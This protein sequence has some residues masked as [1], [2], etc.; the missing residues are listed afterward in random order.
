MVNNFTYS[1]RGLALTESFESCL[2]KAY[3]DVRGVWTIGYGHTGNEV[4]PGLTVTQAQAE[5]WLLEDIQVAVEAVNRL[6]T[7]PLD[8]G[9]FD[10]LCDFT[11]NL[12][13]GSFAGSTLLRDINAGEFQKAADD[14]LE[15][16]HASG[17]VIAGLLRRREEEE[18]LFI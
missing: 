4:H 15:W 9:E 12:G 11:F 10:A 18:A 2:L 16:D 1:K 5:S 7:V 14:L 8:Q 17:K 6:V 3:Q 13:Q